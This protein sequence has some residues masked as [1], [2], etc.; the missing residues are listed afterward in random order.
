MAGGSRPRAGTDA[1]QLHTVCVEVPGTQRP[2]FLF[3]RVHDTVGQ[4]KA[5]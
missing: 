4:L 5:T 3:L 2:V 1:P